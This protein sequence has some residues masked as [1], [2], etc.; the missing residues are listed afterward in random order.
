MRQAQNFTRNALYTMVTSTRQTAYTLLGTIDRKVLKKQ[1]PVFVLSYHSVAKDD[2]RFSVDATV[3]KKQI[4]YLKKNFDIISLKTLE[5]YIAGKVA[6]TKPSVVLTFDDGYKDILTMK[7]YFKKNNITPALFILANTKNPNWKELGSKRSFLTK[8][9]ILSLHKAGW[10]IGC[11]SATHANLATLS[12]KEL[13]EEIVAAKKALQNNLGITIA[14]FAYPRGKYNNTVLQFVKKAKFRMALTMDDGII[15]PNINL[16]TVP[17]VGVDRTHTF[18]EFTSA[19]SPSVV[20]LR[21]AV[22][23]SPI[24]R[25]L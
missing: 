3:L 9:E 19:F 16:L 10:E 20:L 4:Q 12:E 2:W 8:R 23:E 18:K 15:R 14:Y 17:R 21:K 11:H 25:Y 5:D 22:K 6:I 24:G 13:Q 1:N 7:E